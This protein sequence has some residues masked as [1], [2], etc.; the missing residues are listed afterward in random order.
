MKKYPIG[1]K[2]IEKACETRSGHLASLLD[3]AL[4]SGDVCE[5]TMSGFVTPA[6]R[7]V[8][9]EET[10]AGD[11]LPKEFQ[12]EGKPSY[13]ESERLLREVRDHLE[14]LAIREVSP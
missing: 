13:F 14:W 11:D 8:L 5:V 9:P 1:P 7:F 2:T 6:R 10:Y 12:K 3:R 4:Y